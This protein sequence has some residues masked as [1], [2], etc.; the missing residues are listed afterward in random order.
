MN[1]VVEKLI[2]LSFNASII[3][4]LVSFVVSFFHP[5][6]Y[7]NF[8]GGLTYYGA[9]LGTFAV[10]VAMIDWSVDTVRRR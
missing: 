4:I 1:R 5:Q 10:I 7:P 3:M 6:Y 8:F 9:L 2:F